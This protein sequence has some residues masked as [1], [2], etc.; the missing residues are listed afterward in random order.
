MTHF[1]GYYTMSKNNIMIYYN[2]AVGFINAKDSAR[3]IQEVMTTQL[4]ITID[5]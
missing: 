3:R 4:K 5:K 2:A 1:T